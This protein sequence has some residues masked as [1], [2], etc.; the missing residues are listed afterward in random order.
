MNSDRKGL[1]LLS[2]LAGRKRTGGLKRKNHRSVLQSHAIRD[3][4]RDPRREAIVTTQSSVVGRCSGEFY[5]E[6]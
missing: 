5:V 2:E 1:D 6:G 3:E 4:V